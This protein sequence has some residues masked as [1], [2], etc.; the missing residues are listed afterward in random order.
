MVTV[1][2]VNRF[3]TYEF[4]GSKTVILTTNSWVGGKNNFMG[5]A[6]LVTGGLCFI[7]ALAFFLA[8]NAGAPGFMQV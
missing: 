6:Y 7:I 3:N 5:A 4:E 2:V 8:Y 1:D